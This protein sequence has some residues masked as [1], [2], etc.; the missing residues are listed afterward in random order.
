ML[1]ELRHLDVHKSLKNAT[2]KKKLFCAFLIAW[3]QV[4][5]PEARQA[6]IP[7]RPLPKWNQTQGRGSVLP[8]MW[9]AASSFLHPPHE[10]VEGVFGGSGVAAHIWAFCMFDWFWFIFCKQDL[11]QPLLCI[12]SERAE[13]TIRAFKLSSIYCADNYGTS[14]CVW[15]IV[16]S[17]VF[18]S[19]EGGGFVYEENVIK[20]A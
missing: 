15:C 18:F 16:F 17:S 14:F 3:C 10:T 6:K 8:L 12:V 11:K 4:R 5:W 20:R 7:P 13:F 1:T 9:F 2:T 19:G